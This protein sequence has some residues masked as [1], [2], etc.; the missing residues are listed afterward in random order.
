MS[1]STGTAP[2]TSSYG[3]AFWDRLWRQ[4]G[5]HSLVFFLVAYGA[6]SSGNRT[7]I[8]IG[9]VI[10]GMAVLNLMWFA[11]AIRA[12]LADA[13]RDG[14]GAAATASSS[15]LG[16]LLLLLVAMEAALAYS[17]TGPGNDALKP[18]L[19]DLAWAGVVLSSFP[20]AMLIMAG[21]FGFWRAGLISN[22]LF[23]WGVAAVVLVLLGGTTWVSGGFWAPDGIYSRYVSPIIGLIWLVVV[24]RVLAQS[25][26]AR[27]GW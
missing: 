2:S 12:A 8:L 26:G 16:A 14:W 22:S 19:T 27:A 13:G 11:A 18:A 17:I 10:A 6:L 15:A 5:I 23:G 25:P 3:A 21:A 9:S 20:R 4:S 1:A 24:T 7:W